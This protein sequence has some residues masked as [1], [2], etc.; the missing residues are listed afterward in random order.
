VLHLLEEHGFEPRAEADDVVLVNCPFH[1]LAR[2][3]PDLICGMN[4]RLLEGV[5]DGVPG[6]GWA[7]RLQPATGTCCVRMGPGG[8]VG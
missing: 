4:L 5:L 1:T 8:G 6:T 2:D 3:N 7:A